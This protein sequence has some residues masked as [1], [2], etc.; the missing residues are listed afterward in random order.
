ME[1]ILYVNACVRPES[2]TRELAETVLDCLEGSIEEINLEQE[3][4]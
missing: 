2:R 1:K 4:I 3:N